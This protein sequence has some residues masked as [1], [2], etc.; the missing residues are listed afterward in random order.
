M[1][2]CRLILP[3][4]RIDRMDLDTTRTKNAFHRIIGNF[5]DRKTDILIGT[6]MVTK[7]L[8][9]DNVQVVGVLSADNMMSFPDFRAHERSFQLM[10]QVSGRAGR[11]HKQGKV[12]IQSWKP[13][14]PI[15]KCVVKHDYFEMYKQQ[16]VERKRFF[17]PPYYRLIIVKMK[18]KKADLL[19]KG[20]VVF[21][22]ELR[23]KFGKMLY[24][25]EFPLVSRVRSYY[26][27]HIM[28]KTARGSNIKA[29]KGKL[30]KSFLEFRTLAKYKS[31]IIQFDVDPQ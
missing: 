14:H 22:K 5:E 19:R 15:I 13:E 30:N 18:H 10:E 23:T 29:V 2:N 27:M 3:D 8:D 26:I 31:I 7:G 6:Q 17:Y 20:A 1:K 16:L 4:A 25:P 28:I 24:G 11:K 12:V 9:F 21:A